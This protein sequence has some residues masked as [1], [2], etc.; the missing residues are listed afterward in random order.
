MY[1]RMKFGQY[2]PA[3]SILHTL[4]A[5]TKIITT[6]VFLV[7]IILAKQGYEMALITLLTLGLIKASNIKFKIYLESLR[8]FA[9][10]IFITVILQLILVKGR[11]VIELSWLTIS[12]DGLLMAI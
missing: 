7:L 11:P 2:I 9:L 1:S 10:L 3:D 12:R 5:R 4:D 8:P 6:F